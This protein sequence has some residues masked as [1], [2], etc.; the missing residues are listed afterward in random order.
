LA[1]MMLILAIEQSGEIPGPD[2][3]AVVHPRHPGGAGVD[4]GEQNAKPLKLAP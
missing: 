3:L 2:P 4:H 1:I